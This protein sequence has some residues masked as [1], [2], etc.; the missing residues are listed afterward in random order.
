[1]TPI[2]PESYPIVHKKHSDDSLPVVY[3][4]D[5]VLTPARPRDGNDGP[6]F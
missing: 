6:L 2:E 1:M 5:R 4:L 3:L